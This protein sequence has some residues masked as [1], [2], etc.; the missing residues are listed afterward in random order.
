MKR[1]FSYSQVDGLVPQ[2]GAID[3]LPKTPEEMVDEENHIECRLKM[4]SLSPGRLSA[5]TILVFLA[6]LRFIYSKPEW[7]YMIGKLIIFSEPVDLE[8]EKKVLNTYLEMC[9]LTLRAKKTTIQ[10]DL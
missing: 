9:E 3:I 1:T 6:Y 8:I 5:L 2:L 10:E 7:V 4:H